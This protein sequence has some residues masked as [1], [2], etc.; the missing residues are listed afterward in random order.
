M[1]STTRNYFRRLAEGYEDDSLARFLSPIL[2]LASGVYGSVVA[3]KRAAAEK[4]GTRKKLPFPVVSVGN[5]TWGGTGKTPLV[6]FIA[7][8]VGER[9]RKVLILTR[10]YGSD[11]SEQ[12]RNHLQE[13][14]VIGVGKDRYQV[15]QDLLKNHKIDFAILDDGLQHW[16]IHRDFEII[17]IS[18]LNPFGNRKLIPRGILREPLNVLSRASMIVISHANLIS[19]K[20]LEALKTE[21]RQ[22]APKASLIE[23]YLEPLFFYRAKKRA[24]VPLNKLENQKVATFS[25]VGAPR[26][27]QLMLSR[28]KMKPV[29][30]FEFG[31][32]HRFSDHEL[33]EIKEVSDSSALA[34][35][36]TTEKDFFR[37]QES[38]SEIINPLVLA[39]RLR[40]SSGEGVFMQHLAKLLEA[41]V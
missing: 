11:E 25:G 7:R 35:I 8:R 6:E 23:T 3:S 20:E 22:H 24:R 30:N 28:L 34:E 37:C 40:I 26:S 4:N 10:G 29:R 14:A 9:N 13:K 17:T 33:K 18:A 1:A 21:I 15:A 39:T 19:A 2:E 5:L 16:P 12:F 32:H 31:D 36:I 38:I 41:A 27:F